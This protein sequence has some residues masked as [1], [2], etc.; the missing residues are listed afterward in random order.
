MSV[1]FLLV[2]EKR[3]DVGILKALGARRSQIMGIF[4][5]IGITLGVLGIG[6][7]TIL[8][9]SICLFLKKFSFIKL[10]DIYYDTSIPVKVEPMMIATI[11]LFGGGMTLLSALW[12]AIKISKTLPIQGIH[13]LE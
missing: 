4:S 13:K 11:I 6:S 7:G 1:L 12:P 9:L 3:K 10:P 5:F 8:G 2:T